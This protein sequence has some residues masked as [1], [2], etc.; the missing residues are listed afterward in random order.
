[1][2][3][4]CRFILEVGRGGLPRELL[5]LRQ[6]PQSQD[7]G[8]LSADPFVCYIVCFFFFF[9]FLASQSSEQRTCLFLLSLCDSCGTTLYSV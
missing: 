5:G 7:P 1:M 9:F 8:S 2:S 4:C 3:K 6:A